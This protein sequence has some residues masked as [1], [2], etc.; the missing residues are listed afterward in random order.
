[1]TN[2]GKWRSMTRWLA[3]SG[4]VLALVVMTGC[5]T[6][7]P[8]TN[9]AAGGRILLL[10][11][12][13]TTLANEHLGVTVFGNFSEQIENDWDVHGLAE[14]TVTARLQG[15]GYTVIPLTVEQ[16]GFDPARMWLRETADSVGGPFRRERMWL[17]QRAL[18][19]NDAAA[20][21]VL[22][23]YSRSFGP[24]ISVSYSG[25]G[26]SSGWGAKPDNAT[27]FAAVGATVMSGNPVIVNASAT[28]TDSDCRRM[29]STEGLSVDS[30]KRLTAADLAPHRA[31]IE[32]FVVQR[33]EQDLIASG[34]VD[35][36]AEPC[37]LVRL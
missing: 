34:L 35:G 22:G 16:T 19:A 2:T 10:N 20:I 37:A 4:L 9:V 26:I 11:V 1:M 14:R 21:V 3:W 29:I 36:T 18:A 33:L 15:K 24:N 25:Y 12:V 23:A 8:R 7:L 5:M 17:V 28:M 30:L 6:P 27:L 32:G 31:V 13:P